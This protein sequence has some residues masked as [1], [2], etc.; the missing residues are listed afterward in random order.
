[1]L[2]NITQLNIYFI[3]ACDVEWA[4]NLLRAELISWKVRFFCIFLIKAEERKG[5]SSIN[6]K[7]LL[8][9]WLTLEILKKKKKNLKLM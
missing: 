9:N 8:V 4:A 3:K 2:G 6:V 7:Y 1:M 5:F